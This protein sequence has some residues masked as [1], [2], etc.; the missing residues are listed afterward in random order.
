M[1]QALGRVAGTIASQPLVTRESA[2]YLAARHEIFDFAKY[3][4]VETEEETKLLDEPVKSG[5]SAS[6]GSHAK[7]YRMISKAGV[8]DFTGK[9]GDHR[10][11]GRWNFGDHSVAVV[12]GLVYD[13]SFK[14]QGFPYTTETMNSVYVDWWVHAEK[15]DDVY[16]KTRWVDI[17]G[18]REP[19]YE[20]YIPGRQSRAGHWSFSGYV[21]DVTATAGQF[22]M[23]RDRNFSIA[24][25]G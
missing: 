2:I 15:D 13:P 3:H 6:R 19:L 4:P 24:H 1:A 12:G 16:N 14:F 9:F 8:A 5:L 7:W 22:G 11:E 23:T 10:M 18:K 21:A 25:K 17:L 20:Y